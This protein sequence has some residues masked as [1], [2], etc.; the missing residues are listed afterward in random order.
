MS[1]ERVEQRGPPPSPLAFQI[2]AIREI[3]GSLFVF[4]EPWLGTSTLAVR[5]I[6][7]LARCRS[8]NLHNF[9]TGFQGLDQLR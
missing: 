9:L 3:R 1:E 4:F 6:N 2:R 7:L 8:S 5:L